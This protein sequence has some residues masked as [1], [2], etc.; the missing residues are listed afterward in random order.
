MRVKIIDALVGIKFVLRN[1]GLFT[2][3][4]G[5]TFGYNGGDFGIM[6]LSLI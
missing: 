3:T 6:Q 5:F 1:A 4:D 2:T